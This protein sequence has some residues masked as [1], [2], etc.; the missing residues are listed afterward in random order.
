MYNPLDV[1]EKR[2]KCLLRDEFRRPDFD[3]LAGLDDVVVLSV[4]VEIV[5][6]PGVV[7]AQHVVLAAEA[8]DR[9]RKIRAA[10]VG[11]PVGQV[12]LDVTTLLAADELAPEAVVVLSEPRQ[13]ELAVGR[14]SMP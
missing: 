5:A 12:L 1:V 2:R 4:I 13:V 3:L 14:V 8:L 11:R 7:D 6:V 10:E 9:I